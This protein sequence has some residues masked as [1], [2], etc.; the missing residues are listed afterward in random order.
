MEKFQIFA[1]SG[2]TKTDW[3]II[4][5]N[6]GVLKLSSESYHPRNIGQDFINRNQEFWSAF[7]NLH[8]YELHFFGS[9]C[10]K[11]ENA[12]KMQEALIAIGFKEPKVKSDLDA[13]AKAL[14]IVNGWAAISGTGSV[15]FKLENGIVNEVRGGLGRELGD[16][17]SGFYFGKL[18][19]AKILKGEISIPEISF[20][21]LHDENSYSTF[22]ARLKNY[23]SDEGILN[24]HRKNIQ[25]LADKNF[26]GI[27]QISFVGSYAYHLKDVFTSILK[28]KGIIAQKFIERPIDI[29]LDK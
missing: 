15:V 22:A 25:E 3:V 1:D 12:L 16:E 21:E 10:L 9:G 18:L 29:L 17:G 23:N 14:G 7:P 28:E 6:N 8:D 19:A 20:D 11:A 13:A 27:K 5:G 2:G 26:E 4:D 24:L